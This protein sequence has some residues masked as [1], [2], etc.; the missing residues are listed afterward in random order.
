MAIFSQMDSKS[1]LDF[2]DVDVNGSHPNRMVPFTLPK[3]IRLKIDR[4]MKKLKL[5]SGS[6]DMI[7]SPDNEYFFLEV[8]PV[9]QF[10]FISELCN[11]Y[12]EKDI[13]ISLAQ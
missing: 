4:L 9:G 12:I 8:N 3:N 11:Y 10:N 13:A 1:R 6:I 2:R 7:V 5:E